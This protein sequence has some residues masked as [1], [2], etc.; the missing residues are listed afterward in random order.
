[1]SKIIHSLCT[2]NSYVRL[3]GD[4]CDRYPDKVKKISIVSKEKNQD[5]FVDNEKHILDF[6]ELANIFSQENKLITKGKQ[7][8]TCSSDGFYYT[9]NEFLFLEFKDQKISDV[10]LTDLKEKYYNGMSV[11]LFFLNIG[12]LKKLNI[13]CFIICNPE[14]NGHCDTSNNPFLDKLIE[15]VKKD[16]GYQKGANIKINQLNSYFNP[17]RKLGLQ[18]NFKFIFTPNDLDDFLNNL[19]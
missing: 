6:D 19:V 14:K 3:Y 2:R 10:K 13:S 11:L 9:K 16:D 18:L 7:G 5:W 4:I 1:M 17:F 8:T 15:N 12:Y